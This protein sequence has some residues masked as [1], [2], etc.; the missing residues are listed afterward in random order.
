MIEL[1]DKY[2]R[3]IDYIRI[4]VTDRCNLKCIYC[5]PENGIKYTD[6]SELLTFEE[7]EKLCWLLSKIGITKIKITG[8]EPLLRKGICD[9]IGSIKK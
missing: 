8:G 7:I 9:L 1:L 4:S 5:M 3:N 6:K 2:N